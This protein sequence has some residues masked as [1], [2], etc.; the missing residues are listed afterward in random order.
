[1]VNGTM[2]LMS[3]RFSPAVGN[4]VALVLGVLFVLVGL[5]LAFDYRHFATRHSTVTTKLLWP[6]QRRAYRY[7]P[8]RWLP[9]RLVPTT[10][11]DAVRRLIRADQVA[12]WFLVVCGI[13]AIVSTIAAVTIGSG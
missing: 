3:Y 12:G 4:V 9:G 7:P 13:I 6:I 10:R 5:A 1:V 8:W 2:R 11:D